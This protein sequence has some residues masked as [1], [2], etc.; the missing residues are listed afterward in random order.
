M[1]T[2]LRTGWPIAAIITLMASL[3]T[4]SAPRTVWAAQDADSLSAYIDSIGVQEEGAS[5]EVRIAQA[6]APEP[7]ETSPTGTPKVEDDDGQIE[8]AYEASEQ[9]VLT[10][11]AVDRLDT[12]VIEELRLTEAELGNVIRMIGEQMNINFLFDSDEITGQITMLLRNVRLR[13]ALDSI[14]S[15]RKLAIIAD[16]SGIFRIVPQ[17]RVGRKLIETRT[18]VIQLNW[19][20]A[21]D[22]ANTMATFITEEVG[23]IESNEESNSIIITDVPPQIEVIR[24][25]IEQIDIPERQV[26]IEARLIDVNIGALRELGTEWAMTKYNKD[27]ITQRSSMSQSF[28]QLLNRG[29]PA[30][31]DNPSGTRFDDTVLQTVL[32]ETLLGGSLIGS[33]QTTTDLASGGIV[34]MV[35]NPEQALTN[36]LLEGFQFVGGKGTLNFGQELNLFGNVFNLDAAFTALEERNVVE[37]LANP[38]VTTLNNIPSNISIIEK[39]PYREAVQGPSSGTVTEEI[40]FEKAGIEIHAKPIITPD[41]YVRLEVDLMQMIFRGRTDPSDTLSPPLIDERRARTNVIVPGGNTVVLGGLR[42]QR[43]LE[44]VSALPWLH[45]VPLIGW[46]FKNTIHDSSKTELVLM[47]TPKVIKESIGLTD[48]EKFWYDRIDVQW[49]LPD[50]FFDDVSTLGDL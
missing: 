13:D 50:Y 25:L 7:K 40:E 35:T 49:H 17:E 29:V 21:E 26:L 11:E 44:E 47:M 33:S 3:A 16:N 38:R 22:V 46:M 19:I 36:V 18:D 30:T 8:I 5:E 6:G 14:L 43:R 32:N 9:D 23:K 48:R 37:I 24:G 2:L 42:Q 20:N 4:V 31:E 12:T 27:A 34:G 1:F 45:R 41:G 39:I 10:M 15:T 28:G